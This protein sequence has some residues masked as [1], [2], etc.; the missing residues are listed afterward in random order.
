MRFLVCLFLLVCILGCPSQSDTNKKDPNNNNS[1]EEEINFQEEQVL[2]NADSLLSPLDS[3]KELDKK[4]DSYKTGKNL[5]AQD[6]EYNRRLKTEVI[7]GTFDLYELCRLALSSHWDTLLPKDRNYFVNL[8]TRLL[9]RKAIFSKE[10]VTTNHTKPYQVVYKSEK[11]LNREQTKSLV[12]TRILIP[13]EKIDLDIRYELLK[14]PQGWKIYDIIVD[15]ASLVENYKFQ[16]DSIIREHGYH[17]LIA[18][19][20]KKLKEME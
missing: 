12:S 13:S 7:R 14:T 20:E 11:F 9:E 6:K 18:R 16:F 15:D 1:L 5:S 4:L 8:M 2:K 10:R 3:I 17:E 19:M